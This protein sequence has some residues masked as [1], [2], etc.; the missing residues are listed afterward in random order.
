MATDVSRP[1]PD[2]SKPVS[3][4]DVDR[5]ATPQEAGRLWH[6]KL[7]GA[8]AD[9]RATAAARLEKDRLAKEQE[10]ADGE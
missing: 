6:Q 9:E 1:M 2:N 5:P 7:Y 3:L 4:E 8:T 10:T